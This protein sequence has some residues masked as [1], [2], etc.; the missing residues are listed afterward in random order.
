VQPCVDLHGA[1]TVWQTTFPA[2]GRISKK[3]DH[4]LR[5]E[6]L[7]PFADVNICCPLPDRRIYTPKR[8]QQ[9]KLKLHD[10]SETKGYSVLV[11]NKTVGSDPK[12]ISGRW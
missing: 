4:M 3:A 7:S 5:P 11:F 9:Q 1:V 2:H 10:V 8:G 6:N 12:E